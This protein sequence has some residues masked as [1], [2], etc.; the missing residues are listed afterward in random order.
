MGQFL[1][2][3]HSVDTM[4]VLLE[5][6]RAPHLWD[7]YPM[8]RTFP[9][10][11]HGQMTDVFVR[12]RPR[13]QIKGLESHNDEYRCEFWPA[14]RELPSLRPLVFALMAKASAVE[15]GSILITRL[16]PGKKIL[17]HSDRGPWAPEFYNCKAHLTLIGSSLSRCGEDVVTMRAGEA[18]TFDNLIEHEVENPGSEERIVVIVSMRVE[19]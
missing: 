6:Q 1:R 7:D 17:L 15:L 4:P 3:A 19:N 12:F 18:W 13:D 14:W 5:L 8:R 11:A 16:P 2:I 10:T 9:G